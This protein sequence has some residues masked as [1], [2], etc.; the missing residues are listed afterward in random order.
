MRNSNAAASLALSHSP[1][2]ARTSLVAPPSHRPNDLI[3]SLI[4]PHLRASLSCAHRYRC[5]LNAHMAA[6]R[7][8]ARTSDHSG[9]LLNAD[10]DEIDLSS[11]DRALLTLLDRISLTRLF[12][13]FVDQDVTLELL[14]EFDAADFKELNLP[15]GP[16]KQLTKE[17]ERIQSGAASMPEPMEAARFESMIEEL[18][19]QLSGGAATPTTLMTTAAAAASKTQKTPSPLRSDNESDEDDDA[20]DDDDGDDTRARGS[21]ITGRV[22]DRGTEQQQQQQS[23]P[24]GGSVD[25]PPEPPATA[26][27]RVASPSGSQQQQQQQ[28]PPASASST[29]NP[30]LIS[31]PPVVSSPQPRR[32]ASPATAPSS[33]A[34][35]AATSPTPGSPSLRRPLAAPVP[36]P[37]VATASTPPSSSSSSLSRPHRTLPASGTS[38]NRVTLVGTA[39][40]RAG[41]AITATGARLPAPIIAP[42][43]PSDVPPPT[44]ALPPP[45]AALP[46]SI[47]P[48]AS[49]S[50]SGSPSASSPSLPRGRATVTSADSPATS[51]QPP[52]KPQKRLSASFAAAMSAATSESAHRSF[53]PLERSRSSPSATSVA[54]ASPSA[55]G[56]S[57]EDSPTRPAGRGNINRISQKLNVRHAL[58]LCRSC[59]LESLTK[60][61]LPTITAGASDGRSSRN[62]ARHRCPCD[63]GLLVLFVL[64]HKLINECFLFF[65]GYI[66]A[67]KECI[68]FNMIDCILAQVLPEL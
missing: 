46:P 13:V 58:S 11:G 54:P 50:S 40:T 62:G 37:I 27:A 21:G 45:T 8:S 23:S 9:R 18:Y 33:A 28:P 7:A 66:T 17:L 2:H 48:A 16:R 6:K 38:S 53:D 64:R 51:L 36:S 65:F 59:T 57:P 19:Q 29:S 34:A 32:M 61:W 56:T 68:H 12:A 41:I 35:A 39:P 1:S 60:A 44:A 26:P 42:K 14:L 49:L 3:H 43:P 67:H 63:P 5:S 20:E 10:G 24:R 31:T 15:L 30:T 22:D 47:A 55:D 52:A 25:A 4:R